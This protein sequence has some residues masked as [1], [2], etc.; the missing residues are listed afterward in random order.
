MN[1]RRL[2][3]EM[4]LTQEELGKLIGMD[5]PNIV[6]LENSDDSILRVQK[7][8]ILLLALDKGVITNEEYSKEMIRLIK[9]K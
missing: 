2:R 8:K 5:Q 1:Y 6:K 3:K 4:N 9:A 7:M